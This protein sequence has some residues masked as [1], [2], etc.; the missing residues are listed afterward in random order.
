ML[1][2]TDFINESYDKDNFIVNVSGISM[3][4][5]KKNIE[6]LTNMLSPEIDKILNNKK[7][8]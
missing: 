6:D 1:R 2:I 4:I 3:T 8:A 7:G 5:P